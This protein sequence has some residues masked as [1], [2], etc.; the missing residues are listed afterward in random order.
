M[1]SSMWLPLLDRPNVPCTLICRNVP[2]S[3]ASSIVLISLNNAFQRRWQLTAT[4]V[5]CSRHTCSAESASAR[6]TEIGFSAQMP[7]TPARAVSSMMA[8]RGRALVHMLTRS[9]FSRASISR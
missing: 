2:N 4:T 5:P 7:R 6:L 1:V 9:R 3:P 8:A